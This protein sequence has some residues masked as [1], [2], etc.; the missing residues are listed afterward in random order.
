MNLCF[1]RDWQTETNCS[2]TE[3]SSLK[4][5]LRASN[6]NQPQEIVKFIQGNLLA[7]DLKKDNKCILRKNR[8]GIGSQNICNR[9]IPPVNFQTSYWSQRY[10]T[11]SI[12]NKGWSR[13]QCP[14]WTFS[15]L[16]LQRLEGLV[17]S[18]QR[19]SIISR[20][21]KLC[22]RNRKNLK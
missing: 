18:I 12:I 3:W 17:K 5:K 16:R 6:P 21:L 4:S 10:P 22:F 14:L 15:R 2:T 7:N 9:S 20:M 13:K 11:K 19:I 8:L 1:L